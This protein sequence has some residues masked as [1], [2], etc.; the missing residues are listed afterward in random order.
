V[1]R[2]RPTSLVPSAPASWRQRRSLASFGV[3]VLTIPD[4]PPGSVFNEGGSPAGA[5][6]DHPLV[7]S[8]HPAYSEAVGSGACDGI[9]FWNF[10][11]RASSR[12][13]KSVGERIVFPRHSYSGLPEFFSQ[14]CRLL[15]IRIS[16]AIVAGMDLDTDIGS[17]ERLSWRDCVA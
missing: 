15:P 13:R 3:W 11:S 2:R 10:S 14:S 17:D 6:I 16:R 1:P 4:G 7:K 12:A 9:E 5:A 8:L